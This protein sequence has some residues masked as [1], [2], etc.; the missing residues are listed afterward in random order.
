MVAK[1]NLLFQ[2]RNSKAGETPTPQEFLQQDEKYAD[3][4]VAPSFPTFVESFR[5][6][7]IGHGIE[8]VETTR[9]KEQVE[10]SSGC[11]EKKHFTVLERSASELGTNRIHYFAGRF[12]AK[13]AILK[14]LG[15]GWNEGIS[16]LDIEVQ[17]L[18]TGEPSVVLY[19]KCKEIAAELGI[20]KWLLSISH[21][22]SYTAAAAIALGSN[23]NQA[24]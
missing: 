8:I 18:P 21:T 3:L 4:S 22:S 9:I 12:A 23:L 7:I 17:R 14:A 16:W 5:L 13:K 19:A 11:F 6:T 20:A 10:R 24:E 15:R 1:K 2:Q